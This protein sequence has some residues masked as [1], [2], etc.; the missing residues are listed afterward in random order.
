[1]FCLNPRVTLFVSNSRLPFLQIIYDLLLLSSVIVTLS[2]IFSQFHW[3]TQCRICDR[4]RIL[5]YIG[6]THIIMERQ[7]RT[8]V[9]FTLRTA[10][11]G[12]VRTVNR[13]L[14]LQH[15]LNKLLRRDT[16]DKLCTNAW[17][18]L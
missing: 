13:A 2:V 8:K 16:Q 10:T 11:Y 7:R 4:S 3:K 1:M 5:L 17:S 6:A 9:P 18:I 14:K 12:D 15:K